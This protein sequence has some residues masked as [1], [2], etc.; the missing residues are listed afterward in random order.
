MRSRKFSL[1]IPGMGRQQEGDLSP[2]EHRVGVE[3]GMSEWQ[4]V[5]GWG[6]SRDGA[7]KPSLIWSSAQPDVALPL[8]C[9]PKEIGLKEELFFS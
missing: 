2:S 6:Q 4:L 7:A 5:Q 8:G 3:E 9:P 1:L